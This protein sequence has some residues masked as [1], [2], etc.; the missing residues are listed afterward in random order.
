MI[1]F[2]NTAKIWTSRNC[3]N[4]EIFAFESKI[5]IQTSKIFNYEKTNFY[6]PGKLLITKKCK[7]WNP[8]NFSIQKTFLLLKTHNFQNPRRIFQYKEKHFLHQKTPRSPNSNVIK[9]NLLVFAFKNH[10]GVARHSDTSA[11]V[12]QVGEGT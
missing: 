4:A 6:N 9:S 11:V 7:F 12:V 8:E 5:R 1:Q 3:L 2:L 10:G